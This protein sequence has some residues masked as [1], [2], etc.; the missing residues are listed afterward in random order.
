MS[1]SCMG[2]RAARAFSTLLRGCISTT[3]TPHERLVM[4]Q[5]ALDLVRSHSREKRISLTVY[6]SPGMLHA[7]TSSHT[8]LMHEAC[9]SDRVAP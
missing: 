8:A 5:I 2:F 6:C 4:L 1:S 9:D 3:F 7:H